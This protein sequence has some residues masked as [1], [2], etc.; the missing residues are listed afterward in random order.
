MLRCK[1]PVCR[2]C[3]TRRGWKHYYCEPR[4]KRLD[5]HQIHRAAR[6]AAQ[7]ARREAVTG[8]I[9]RFCGRDDSEANQFHSARCCTRCEKHMRCYTRCGLCG[10]PFYTSRQGGHKIGCIV[11]NRIPLGMSCKDE[12]A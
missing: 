7:K 6:L 10:G 4:C 11:K 2:K 1:R 5:H 3:F 12:V 8:R 9:C